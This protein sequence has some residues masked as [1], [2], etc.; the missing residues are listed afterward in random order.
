MA[1]V[2]SKKQRSK[3]MAA[4]KGKNNKS[5][6]IAL[7]KFFRSNKINGWRRHFA[8]LTGT[9]DFIFPE[10]KIAI[11]VD[12]CFWHGCKRCNLR[13]KTHT[14]FWDKKISDN[15]K[16]DKLVNKLLKRKGWK[17]LRFWEHQI[18]NKS[19]AKN[20]IKNIRKLINN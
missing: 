8:R 3:N 14:K 1:D 16:R 6:E 18:K 9:P 13:P 20:I 19:T 10:Q 11:F 4:I 2:H 17:V 12:G 7:L 15:F 5:T